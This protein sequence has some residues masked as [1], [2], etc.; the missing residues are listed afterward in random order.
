MF[1]D[2]GNFVVSKIIKVMPKNIV[3]KLADV[4]RGKIYTLSRDK[5]ACRVIQRLLDRF[6]PDEIRFIFEEL[7]AEV[8]ALILAEFGNYV[9]SHVLLVGTHLD[10]CY[11]ID[12]ILDDIV[13]LSMHKFG[14]NVVEKCLELAPEDKRESL[15]DCIIGVPVSNH[16]LTLIDLMNSQFA[17]YVV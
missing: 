4:C 12:K 3:H 7:K 10:K 13:Q 8:N 6:P 1:D 17:N 15:L 5:N 9:L 16:R 14:S 2:N 11:I